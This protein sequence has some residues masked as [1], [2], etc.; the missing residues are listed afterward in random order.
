MGAGIDASVLEMRRIE[1]RAAD[2]GSRDARRYRVY[3]GDEYWTVGRHDHFG[4]IAD[5]FWVA[6]FAST[7]RQRLPDLP[8]PLWLWIGGIMM[9]R[10]FRQP[11]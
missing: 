1:L 2:A 4:D 10:E 5:A 9:R 3:W 11:R 7:R 6:V 8:P